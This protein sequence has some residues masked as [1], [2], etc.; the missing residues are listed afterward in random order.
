MKTVI[1]KL[2]AIYYYCS[3][4]MSVEELSILNANAKLMLKFLLSSLI[5]LLDLENYGII[6]KKFRFC[7]QRI[8][9]LQN[10]RCPKYGSTK[11][12]PLASYQ[13]YLPALDGLSMIKK[14]AITYAHPIFFILKLSPSRGFNP[15][16]YHIIK[17]HI[18]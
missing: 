16:A 2:K 8:T 11:K 13:L 1:G 4:F 5:I 18:I 7:K 17:R 6:D 10:N 14:A 15:T 3:L 9:S 12:L